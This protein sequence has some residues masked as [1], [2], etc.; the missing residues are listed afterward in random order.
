MLGF[1]L[2]WNETWGLRPD[3]RVVHRVQIC[4]GVVSGDDKRR[5]GEA[6]VRWREEVL[7]LFETPLSFRRQLLQI[8][9]AKGWT[10]PTP[11]IQALVDAHGLRPTLRG[12]G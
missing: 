7:T 8:A 6:G 10:P 11:E 1:G 4:S 12:D 2:G 5:E 9:L 3:G